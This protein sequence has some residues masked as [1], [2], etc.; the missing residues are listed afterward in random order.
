MN[1]TQLVRTLPAAASALLLATAASADVID[2]EGLPTGT[3]VSSLTSSE[4]FGPV[5]V[6]GYNPSFG[7]GVNAA[8]I[9]DSSNPTGGDADLGSPHADFGGPGHGSGGQAGATYEN[10]TALGK[11][12]IIDEHLNTDSNG[13]VIDPDDATLMGMTLEFDFSALGSV[14][15]RSAS[16]ID[17]E[18][19]RPEG[20]VEMFDASD[21]SLGSVD[22]VHVGDNGVNTVSLGDTRDVVRVVVT[23][24]GSGA[25]TGFEFF[26]PVPPVVTCFSNPNSTGFVAGASGNGSTSIQ[27][28]QFSVS[29]D[30]LPPNQPAY[31]FYGTNGVNIPFGSGVQCIGSPLVR[32]QKVPDIPASGS[33]TFPLDLASS[34]FDV[35][36]GEVVPGVPFY[37]Q[38]WYRDPGSNP[39][40][41]MTDSLCVTFMP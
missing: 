22:L 25:F 38:L 23:L 27:D 36:F 10:A 18:A 29:F 19:S 9:F 31:L 12:L 3:I 24:N 20:S 15:M 39:A 17:I 21:V 7:H 8:V 28:N 16:Y 6:E 13:L 5:L 40:F 41:N 30:N 33:V 37:F 34:P 14:V 2:F 11:I 4:G 26:T 35:G 1:H 32:Y